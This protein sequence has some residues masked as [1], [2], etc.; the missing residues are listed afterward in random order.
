MWEL[1]DFGKQ[2]FWEAP[3]SNI[4]WFP[5]GN[6]TNCRYWNYLRVIFLHLLPAVVIDGILRLL[7]KKPMYVS[8]CCLSQEYKSYAIL[9]W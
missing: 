7:N 5:G 9:G 2:I 3:I 8:N 4:L 6:M 1:L